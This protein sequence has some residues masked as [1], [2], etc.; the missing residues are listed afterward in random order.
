M[1]VAASP[2]ETSREVA[3]R[4]VV[5]FTL[6]VF[7]LRA[8]ATG[9]GGFMEGDEISIASGISAIVRDVPGVTYR[10]GVQFGYYRLV[11]LLTTIAGGDLTR[12]PII[13]SWL[14]LVAGV[15]IPLCGLFAFRAELTVRERWLA[16]ALLTANPIIWL[17]ARYGNTAMPSVACT[18]V[19]ITILSNRPALLGEVLAMCCFAL[20]I[21]LRADAVLV[22]GGVFFLLWRNHRSFVRA[23]L[24]LAAVGGTILLLLLALRAKDPYMASVADALTSHIANPIRTRFFDFLLWAISPFPLFFA[25]AG[26][27]E[28]QRTRG[29]LFL[30]LLAWVGPPFA[31]YFTGTTTPRYLLQGVVPLTLAAAVGMWSFVESGGARRFVSL[32]LVFGLGFVHL[33]IGMSDFYPSRARSFLKDAEIASDDGRVWTGALLYK[34]YVRNGLAPGRVLTTHF[35]ATG[36]GERSLAALFDTVATGT[37]RGARVLVVSAGGYGNTLHFFAHLAGAAPD[38]ATPCATWDSPC[39]MQLGGTRLDVVSLAALR[40]TTQVVDVR[41]GEEVWVVGRESDAARSELAPHLPPS[42][43]LEAQPGWTSAP[44]MVR[45]V[46]R[47]RAS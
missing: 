15:V 42:L 43:A 30:A 5:I 17:S 46:T 38:R 31:F 37:R 14:S 13:M 9:M 3:T 47:Q 4:H 16:A 1:S 27:R 24:P 35:R 34:S 2:I 19:A 6:L 20:G 11:A 39:T 21:T 22:S 33:F 8:L 41:D 12:I 45:F 26:L 29:T 25:A 10:Y 36:G 40:G 32:A 44:R 7:L 28:A 23:T 18:A